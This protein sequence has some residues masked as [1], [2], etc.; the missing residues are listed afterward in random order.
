MAQVVNGDELYLYQFSKRRNSTKRPNETWYYKDKTGDLRAGVKVVYK[1]PT[2]MMQPKILL[3]VDREGEIPDIGTGKFDSELIRNCNYAKLNGKYYWIRNYV[4]ISRDHWEIELIRDPLATYRD[5]IGET[6]VFAEYWGG[7]NYELIDTRLPRRTNGSSA[8]V[9]LA[10]PWQT[11]NQFII[12]IIGENGFDYYD[13]QTYSNYQT[14]M[15]SLN[16]WLDTV[17]TIAYETAPQVTDYII[18]SAT[19]GSGSTDEGNTAGVA[20]AIKHIA[21]GIGETAQQTM[22]FLLDTGWWMLKTIYTWIANGFSKKEIATMITCA[23]YYP[24]KVAPTLGGGAS[25]IMI[26]NYNTGV[27][28]IR[29]TQMCYRNEYTVNVPSTMNPLVQGAWSGREEF[30]HW[31]L[32]VPYMGHMSVPADLVRAGS[33]IIVIQTNVNIGSGTAHFR[34]SIKGFAGA[35]T[36]ITLGTASVQ[37]GGAL[38]MGMQNTNVV[39]ALTASVGTAGGLV[40]SAMG[41]AKLAAATTPAGAA[42]AIGMQVAGASAAANS[43]MHFGSSITPTGTQISG[44]SGGV[45]L[46]PSTAEGMITLTMYHFDVSETSANLAKVIG[47]PHFALAKVKN[48]GGY[49]KANGASFEANGATFEEMDIV[50]SFLNNGLYY[51]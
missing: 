17:F 31:N 19:G 15:T 38:N 34:I 23:W 6:N 42:A 40:A 12:G 24:V 30:C 8:G 14:F 10:G 46:E 35:T 45:K 49:V 25:V 29:I 7:G 50:N 36:S 37:I 21:E 47:V 33:S 1:N 43:A 32:Y 11:G 28:G 41:A 3:A 51:E 39:G 48:C 18:P 44:A 5:E 26:G 27:S 22:S 9:A 2:S 16:E 13:L 4:S 20:N